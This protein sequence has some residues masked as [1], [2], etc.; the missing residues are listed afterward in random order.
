M[1]APTTHSV[2]RA[3]IAASSLF[4][5]PRWR[6]TPCRYFTAGAVSPPA[7]QHIKTTALNTSPTS[8]HWR[9]VAASAAASVRR[10]FLSAA[11]VCETAWSSARFAARPPEADIVKAQRGANTR[12]H[13]HTS[14]SCERRQASPEQR[15]TARRAGDVHHR[16][17]A[18][19]RPVLRASA[20]REMDG[21]AALGGRAAH[22]ARADAPPHK[23]ELA[24]TTRRGS[25]GRPTV[26][27]AA[28]RRR[29][30]ENEAR[31]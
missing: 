12:A 13:P 9:L 15:N 2:T 5:Q 23:R 1:S 31:N 22:R 30:P 8:T 18:G 6:A 19:T 3:A 24:Q 27:T 28:S 4:G 14:P 20:A 29:P 26:R 10:A 21:R 7:C 17:R 16:A 25:E 11:R